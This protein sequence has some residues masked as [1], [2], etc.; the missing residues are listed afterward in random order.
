VIAIAYGTDKVSAAYAALRGGYLHAL[1]THT[2][3]AEQLLEFEGTKTSG[4]RA[5]PTTDL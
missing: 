3:F 4:R 1:V 2:R 5:K